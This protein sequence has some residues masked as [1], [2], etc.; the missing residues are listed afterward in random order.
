M[1]KE[2]TIKGIT[3]VAMVITIV[4]LLILAGI[5]ISTL[6]NTGLFEKTRKAK[7]KSENAQIEENLII[8]SYENKINEI[9]GEVTGSRDNVSENDEL[10]KQKTMSETEHFTG[11]YYL[12]NKPIYA[13]TILYLD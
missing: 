11:E 9:S 13:K 3:L 4:V 5:A 10:R 8:G 6:T 12:D 7:E 2:K 1:T